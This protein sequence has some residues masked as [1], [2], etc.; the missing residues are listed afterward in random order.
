MPIYK[1]YPQVRGLGQDIVTGTPVE[2]DLLVYDRISSTWVNKP[3][4][5]DLVNSWSS[6]PTVN[7]S[8]SGGVV[9]DYQYGGSGYY[10]FVPEPYD[11]SLDQFFTGFDGTDLTGLIA[12][13]SRNIS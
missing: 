6:A 12:T 8:I 11:S 3:T 2:G 10:R 4:W 5:S 7:S 9:W 13:R 1:S